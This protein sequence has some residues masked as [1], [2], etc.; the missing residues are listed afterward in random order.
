LII[1]FLSAWSFAL[2]TAANIGIGHPARKG[3]IWGQSLPNTH[4]GMA[5]VT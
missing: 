3:N 5:S 1:V 2:L 4:D